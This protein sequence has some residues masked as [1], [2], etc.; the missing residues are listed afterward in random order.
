MTTTT[1]A[2]AQA[3]AE[4]QAEK[5]AAQPR[6]S[7]GRK[8]VAQQP[9]APAA[10]PRGSQGNEAAKPAKQE[11]AQPEGV[12]ITPTKTKVIP[13]DAEAPNVIVVRC[14][15]VEN[16]PYAH[17]LDL[18]AA[19]TSDA[20]I[21]AFKPGVKVN[22]YHAG[23]KIVLGQYQMIAKGDWPAGKVRHWTA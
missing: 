19:I 3:Q 1:D 6:A 14:M 22:V 20:K 8:G 17:N 23:S 15:G 4:T 13:G 11:K 18:V 9:E 12:A 2:P 7:R 16:S 21:A 5:P 10:Q